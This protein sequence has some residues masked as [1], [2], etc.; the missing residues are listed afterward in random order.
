MKLDIKA[1]AL[2]AGLIWGLAMLVTGLANLVCSGYGQAF[3]SAMASIYPGYHASGSLFDTVVGSL[4]GLVDGG[5]GG[6]V[7]AWLY[8]RFLSCGTPA[9]Q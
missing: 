6:L 3:L 2:T 1:M 8:N 9:A 5:V 4:Y 7:F